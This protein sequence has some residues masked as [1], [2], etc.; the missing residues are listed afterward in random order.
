MN[1][2]IKYLYRDASNYKSWNEVIISGEMTRDDV[3]RIQMC[4]FDGEYFVPRDVGLPETRI[5]DYR[6]DDDHCWFEWELGEDDY[7]GSLFGFDL[8]N[9]P[10]T[11]QMTVDELVRNFESVKSWDETSWMNDYEYMSYDEL[12]EE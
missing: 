11:L 5:A 2:K 12:L 7:D 3:I 4:L 9:E 1:T 10:P 6:T 8:T